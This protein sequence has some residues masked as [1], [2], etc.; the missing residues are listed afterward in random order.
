M[1]SERMVASVVTQERG[2]HGSQG[3]LSAERRAATAEEIA[4]IVGA[5]ENSTTAAIIATGATRDE[6]L[7]ANTWLNA[8]NDMHRELHH[9]PRGVV[10][11]VL[12]IL[13]AEIAPPEER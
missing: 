1:L 10:A 13:E 3:K 7:E 2:R 4:D 11:R 8:D 12:D 5:V 9:M 6:V